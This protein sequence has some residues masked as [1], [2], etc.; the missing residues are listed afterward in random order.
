MEITL[1]SVIF[2]EESDL[3]RGRGPSSL[4]SAI[5]S[6]F[7]LSLKTNKQFPVAAVRLHGNISWFWETQ[8]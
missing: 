8:I 6:L 2:A 3:R 1:S 5:L 7:E 4:I